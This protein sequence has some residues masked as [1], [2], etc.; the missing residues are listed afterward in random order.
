MSKQGYIGAVPNQPLIIHSNKMFDIAEI[1]ATDL[2]FTS[3]GWLAEP[4]KLLDNKLLKK[5][6]KPQE[7]K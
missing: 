6:T 2:A 3:S 5:L 7:N 4:S 1:L